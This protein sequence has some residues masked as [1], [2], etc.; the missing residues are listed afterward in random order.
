[1]AEP[2]D[3]K[4][5]EGKKT[6][7]SVCCS[8]KML[9]RWFMGMTIFGCFNILMLTPFGWLIFNFFFGVSAAWEFSDIQRGILLKVLEGDRSC[10]NLHNTQKV[11]QYLLISRVNNRHLTLLLCVIFHLGVLSLRSE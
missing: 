3:S 9:N 10:D 8:T 2:K 6:C 7:W 1:M 11:L 5:K 4:K